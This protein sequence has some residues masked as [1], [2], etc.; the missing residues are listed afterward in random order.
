MRL[1][2]LKLNRCITIGMAMDANAAKNNGY[3]QLIRVKNSV[4]VNT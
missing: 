1:N 3:N 4:F 2:R